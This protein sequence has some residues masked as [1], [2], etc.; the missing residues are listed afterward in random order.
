MDGR[1]TL[2]W[3]LIISLHSPGW[4]S[5]TFHGI[6]SGRRELTAGKGFI[7]IDC[8]IAP[9]S[10]YI[11]DKLQIPYI[12]DEEFI[13][14][15]VNYK[16]SKDYSDEDALKQFMNVRSFPEGNKN[17]YTLR[18]EGGKGNKYL[19][20]ARF[21]YGNYDSNNHLPKFKLYL[22]TDEWVTVNI[23]DASAYIREEIIHVP[24]TDDIYVCLVNIGGGTPFISTLELRPL[25]NS[26]Y[27]QSEQGSLLL[28]NRWDFCKPEN[29]LHRPDDVFDRIWNLS[30][31]SNEWDTLE[32]AYEISSLSHS[33]YKLPMSVMMD[34]VI[35][36]D[37]SEPW[38]FSLD[39]DDDP[40]QNLYIYMHFA[41]VQ[42]LREGDIREFTVS[43]N[44]DDSWGGGEP[45]IPNY[46]V[47]NTLHH[48]SAVSG[49]TTNELSFA[50]KKTNRS[51][52]PPLINAMEVY[53]IKDFAQS[54]TKQGDVLAVKN[55][56]SAY[57]LTR[58]WQGDPCLP[59]DF[60]WD[61]LQCSYSSDSPTII[62]L[63]AIVNVLNLTGN[64]L[65]GS[66]PQTIMEMFKDKDR[67]LSLGANPNLC[68]SVSCQGKEKKKKNRFLVPVLIAILTVTVILVLITALA[69]IIRKFKRR[70]TKGNSEFTFSDVA[71]ITN[72]FSRTIG[73]GG[74][75]QVYL[76]T[77]A[78]GTQVA[79]KMRS[80]S[81][82][83][84][85]KALRAEVKLLT[86]VH[87]KNL[88]RLIGYCNDGTNIALV[89]EYMSNGNLQQK[90]SGRAAADVLNW[91]QRLQIAV[92]AAH[93]LEYLHNGCKPPIVH[94]DMKSSNTLLTET[95]E[96][97]IADFGMSRDLESGALLSTDPVGTPG[98]L[99]P[100]YQLTGN[101]NKKSDVYSF[102]IV[103]LELITGQPAIKNPGSIHIVGWVGPM[104]ER[105][106][107]QSI[108]DPRLQGDFH[109]NSAWKALEIALACVALT[110]MQR[111][112]MS[113][114]LADL[115]ECLEI[116][117]ASRR[118]QSVSHSI[119]SGNFLED[120][121]LTLGTQSAPRAT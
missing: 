30:A 119:G 46:M 88:V 52:L 103:L 104:I 24:T 22:G 55:I 5:G 87:H 20:R 113:H 32:A 48:P 86:R 97:K 9:G 21:M 59:L 56:R 112:D 76:G 49:S 7:S 105:G 10:N 29:A 54:S 64:Q 110:G 108:V 23:E 73:R 70:E 71:S 93:G 57:R 12:S 77:L 43:L 27:D 53:K 116:E 44:E 117:M 31:W 6:Q 63:L 92:D 41:E 99:D 62:S 28:F 69:M 111:P 121:P 61:G 37:I 95:L 102:G 51:T 34:A 13:D 100:E 2:I 66:V 83:Q 33:E 81:S 3:L 8:G 16:V 75:G 58:H 38:N 115:K 60:P 11:D 98:Y 89:Y 91:K 36:V 1:P 17:C 14:T 65:T 78:D 118:T 15:G 39:L 35:P 42:K 80:E 94:R 109:T 84:G 4:V 120:S 79:V 40:S 101:L 45:V 72:N 47:S 67:T 50:L 96:A 82:M 107:I 74:F 68:P 26:I 19:I 18:P 114:V 25:N 90:L 85:P 106:D